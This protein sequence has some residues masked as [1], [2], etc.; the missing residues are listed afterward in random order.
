FEPVPRGEWH[1]VREP[2][3]FSVSELELQEGG[4]VPRFGA[5]GSPGK[6]KY[7]R[8]DEFDDSGKDSWC[9]GGLYLDEDLRV[10]TKPGR[11]ALF[12]LLMGGGRERDRVRIEPLLPSRERKELPFRKIGHC[13]VL[14]FGRNR[15]AIAPP[16]IQHQG[17]DLK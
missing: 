2:E 6:Y 16:A 5:R 3:D 17:V 1:P 7:P 15:E 13:L 8:V 10:L 14:D 4:A 12:Q 11:V 9:V